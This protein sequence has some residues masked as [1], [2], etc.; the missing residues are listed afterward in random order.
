MSNKGVIMEIPEK[1]KKCIHRLKVYCKGYK[2]DIELL[3]ID[4][5]TRKKVKKWRKNK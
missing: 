4:N 1:C 5:C 2:A 3:T